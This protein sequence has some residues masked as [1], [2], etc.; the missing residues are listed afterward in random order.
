MSET[1]QTDQ[2]DS[3]TSGVTLRSQQAIHE[4]NAR[5]QEENAVLRAEKATLQGSND[6]LRQLVEAYASELEK[7]QE[8]AQNCLNKSEELM[9]KYEKECR[10]GGK[11]CLNME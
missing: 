6:R 11:I 7:A 1:T 4:E 2:P 5:L 3:T 10:K 9:E 8:I